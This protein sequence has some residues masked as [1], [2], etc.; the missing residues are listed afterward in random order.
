MRRIV[1]LLWGNRRE[2]EIDDV[3]EAVR[4]L[5]NDDINDDD[6]ALVRA[7]LAA[8]PSAPAPADNSRAVTPD[9]AAALHRALIKSVKIIDE[10]A[11]AEVPMPEPWPAMNAADAYARLTAA[12]EIPTGALYRSIAHEQW[13]DSRAALREAILTY[14]A[15]R[16]AAAL[17]R[18]RG[19]LEAAQNDAMRFRW[20]TEDHADPETRAKCRELLSRMGVMTYSSACR[21]IDS[22]MAQATKR[23]MLRTAAE[24]QRR[25]EPT[26]AHGRYSDEDC[27]DCP[28]T[29]AAARAELGEGR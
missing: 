9:E 23:E 19:V 5:V 29:A 10:P 12:K 3:V 7:V 20:L 27:T 1:A 13:L 2:F 15:A 28:R 18:V 24:W 17:E 11:P 4:K 25:Y 22:A 16:E 21:D 14:A 8:A 26:C 6:E